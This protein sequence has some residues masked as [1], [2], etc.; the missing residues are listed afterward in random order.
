MSKES[1]SYLF[2]GS[3]INTLRVFDSAQVARD[4]L[5]TCC[6]KLSNESMKESQLRKHH[7]SAKSKADE[8]L[9]QFKG[10]S[11]GELTST[12]YGLEEGWKQSHSKVGRKDVPLISSVPL[13]F[14]KLTD[15]LGVQQLQPD[16]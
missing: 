12:I 10:S 4:A 5:K 1:K 15:S 13:Y 7:K 9:Q 8:Q 11:F 3:T 16:L 2:I 6:E 14:N